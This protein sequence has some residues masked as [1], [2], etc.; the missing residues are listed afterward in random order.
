M[1]GGGDSGRD[2]TQGPACVSLKMICIRIVFWYL[3]CLVFPEFRRFMV[4]YLINLESSWLLFLLCYS[5]LSFW[6]SNYTYFT[7]F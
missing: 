6:Y 1:D 2:Q 7:H 5:F 3:S 4:G